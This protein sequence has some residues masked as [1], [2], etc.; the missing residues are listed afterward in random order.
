M[1]IWK[2]VKEHVSPFVRFPEEAELPL[3]T[4]DKENESFKDKIKD[5]EKKAQVGIEFTWKF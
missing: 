5:T 4:E 2:W 3:G 1:G